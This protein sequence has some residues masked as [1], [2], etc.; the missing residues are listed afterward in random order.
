LSKQIILPNSS[1]AL[2]AVYDEYAALLYG[3]IFEV[4]KDTQIAEQYLVSV[5]NELPKHLQDL[6]QPGVNTYLRLQLITRNVLAGYFETIPACDFVADD[7]SH[8]PTRPNKFLDKMTHEQQLVFCNIHY[9]GKTIRGLA[10]EM[11]KAEDEIKKIL[12]EAF[13]AIRRPG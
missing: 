6:V 8:M 7:N 10:A 12:Q 1:S 11:N 2:R 4:V 5:F 9:S 3:Y 13:A